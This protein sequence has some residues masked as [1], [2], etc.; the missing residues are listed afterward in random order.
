MKLPNFAWLI[1][2]V[3]KNIALVEDTSTASQNIA[4]GE[5]VIWKGKQKQ[6]NQAISAGDT[7]SSTNLNDVPKGICNALNSNIN[8]PRG[9][10]SKV[11]NTGL[12][13]NTMDGLFGGLMDMA[14][15]PSRYPVIIN[16]PY[17]TSQ[18]GAQIAIDVTGATYIYVRVKV[19][20]VW[21]AW[22]RIATEL[23]PT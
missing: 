9:G 17:S 11:I 21:Q 13:A 12:D 1:K 4:S 10:V 5:Y 2:K 6:A 18:Y 19:D 8:L 15:T 16:L 23:I 22:R 7:L 20:N 3:M 14:N